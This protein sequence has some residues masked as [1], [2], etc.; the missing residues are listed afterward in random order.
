VK[1]R[2]QAD[3]DLN[4]DIVKGLFRREPGIDF[5]TAADAKLRGL[6]DL[7]VLD[8]AAS[9]NRVLVSHDRKTMPRAFAKFLQSRQS[10]GVIIISQKL[11]LLTAIDAL[12]LIWSA[13]EAEEWKNRIA[14][15]PF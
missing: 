14:S 1:L 5:R 3:A 8:L 12:L 10:P 9:D 6:S 13:S 2:F 4:D 11:D 15:V 7:K